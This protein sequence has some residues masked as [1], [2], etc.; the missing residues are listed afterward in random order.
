MLPLWNHYKF[1]FLFSK[2]SST[3]LPRKV[4][5]FFILVCTY[6]TSNLLGMYQFPT[7]LIFS[8]FAWKIVG[9]YH[10]T[11]LFEIFFFF[12]F[13]FST[14]SYWMYLTDCDH[15][16]LKRCSKPAATVSDYQSMY[17]LLHTFRSLARI[18][19]MRLLWKSTYTNVLKSLTY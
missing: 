6:I 4:P 7:P 12:F 8:N 3:N 11:G 15:L 16:W 9:R 17:P 18:P 14:F 13:A 5:M 1:I 10:K 2:K 19:S